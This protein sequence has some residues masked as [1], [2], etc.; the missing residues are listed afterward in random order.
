MKKIGITGSLAS[1][2]STAS[3]ILS[4]KKGPLFSADVVVKKLYQKK[5]FRA[6]VSKKLK[7][8]NKIN[9]KAILRNKIIEDQSSLKKIEAIIHPLVRNEM[10][11]FVKKNKKKKLI[12]FEIPLLIESKLMKNYD[13]IIFIKANKKLRLKRFI[14]K[15]G[16][17]RFFNILNKKQLGDNQKA[18]FSNHVVVN[19]KNIKILKRN[20]L[21]ILNLYE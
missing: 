9:F 11:S 16:N 5:S 13:V 20:L 6:L 15:G 18:K 7:I 2:K 3:K 4:K 14:K 21:N 1:G 17:E 8:K 12:F 19:E 10:K